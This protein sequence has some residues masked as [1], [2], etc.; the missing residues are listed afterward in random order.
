MS[1]KSNDNNAL[2]MFSLWVP[3]TRCRVAAKSRFRSH[4]VDIMPTDNDIFIIIRDGL[5]I[6]FPG[7]ELKLH[8]FTNC[9]SLKYSVYTVV[10]ISNEQ[11]FEFLKVPSVREFDKFKTHS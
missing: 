7:L 4:A 10:L 3:P 1:I 6:S 2:G 11:R 5:N 9:S 8:I